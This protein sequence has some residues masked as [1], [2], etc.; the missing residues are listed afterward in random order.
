MDQEASPPLVVMGVCGSGKSTLGLALAERLRL[1]Y[2][3][4]DDF[5][6]AANVVKMSAGTPLTDDD[7]APWLEA[8]GTWLAERPSGAVVSCSALRKTYRD[9]LRRNAPDARFVHLAGD[10]EVISRRVAGRQDHFMPAS[11]IESQQQLLEPLADDEAGVTLDL[12][13]ALDDLLTHVTA[14]LP[15]SPVG[16]AR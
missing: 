9:A 15:C 5:H 10:S 4:A 2:A 14:A 12:E 1:P 7:R 3:D 8:I 11:L 6:P 13:R 16:A